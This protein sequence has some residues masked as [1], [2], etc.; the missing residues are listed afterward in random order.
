VPYDP[1]YP[2][3]KQRMRTAYLFWTDYFGAECS[4]D[5]LIDYQ[6]TYLYATDVERAEVGFKHTQPRVSQVEEADD[7]RFL[8]ALSRWQEEQALGQLLV[9]ARWGDAAYEEDL[10][11]V[12]DVLLA[13]PVWGDWTH[14]DG[15]ALRVGQ[16][17]NTVSW[18][19]CDAILWGSVRGVLKDAGVRQVSQASN[20]VELHSSDNAGATKALVGTSGTG[21]NGEY[22][23]AVAE[24]GEWGGR[25]KAPRTYYLKVGNEWQGLGSFVNVEKRWDVLTAVLSIWPEMRMR[26]LAGPLIRLGLQ[27]NQ[28]IAGSRGC[29]T[30]STWLPEGIAF[31]DVGAWD[32]LSIQEL[33]CG[34]LLAKAEFSGVARWAVNKTRGTSPGPWTEVTGVALVGADL[35]G[36]WPHLDQS[37]TMWVAGYSAED[38]K[39]FVE[40]GQA[41]DLALELLDAT[42][43]KSKVV[44]CTL[45]EGE[46]TPCC[47]IVRDKDGALVV[48]VTRDGGTVYYKDVS[49]GASIDDFTVMT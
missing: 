30:S 22:P 18:I 48:S 25:E 42:N 35:K 20:T 10:L 36:W 34:W 45:G 8:K 46:G 41:T 12:D 1:A 29:G 13:V 23:L 37:G 39:I 24:G 44:D 11:D 15:F 28:V 14:E 40:K 43:Y 33:A 5:G 4:V 49:A 32:F 7:M 31:P 47:K 3:D 17:L 26:P 19:C 2:T 16:T 27:G 9:T 6:P 38:S 21:Y